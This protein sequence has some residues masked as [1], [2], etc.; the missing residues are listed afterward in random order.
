MSRSLHTQKLSARALR[1]M[2]RPRSK[3]R[4]EAGFLSGRKRATAD[5]ALPRLTIFVQ[6]PL[7]GMRHAVTPRDVRDVFVR[8]GPASTYGLKC[9]RLRQ[10]CALQSAGIVFG[11]YLLIGEI[12]L[13]SLPDLPW[14]LP[15]L[16]AAR[17]IAAFE[18]FGACIASRADARTTTIA[19]NSDGQR[20]FV[21]SEVLAHELG[22]HLLQ[23]GKGKR[24]A[25]VCRRSDHER[26][27]DLQCRR[28]RRHIEHGTGPI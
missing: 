26:R 12:Y 7:P 17:D 14:H 25:V 21:L 27:A 6:K 15:Y 19:W 9:V 10:E 16:L 3:R 11:E 22:H 8:L 24:K 1:R 5:D 13:Y 23:R 2:V 18:R 28:A 4:E 20:E